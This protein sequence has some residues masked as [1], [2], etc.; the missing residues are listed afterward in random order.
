[1]QIVERNCKGPKE[2]DKTQLFIAAP[3]L[4]N[5]W[6]LLGETTKIVAVS[7]QRIASI[8]TNSG[9]GAAQVELELIGLAGESVEMGFLEPGGKTLQ[10]TC[11]IGLSGRVLMLAGEAAGSGQTCEE[12]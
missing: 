10:L 8:S 11:T 1:M 12:V 6:V 5:N 7:A 3:V 4:S 9:V 2:C